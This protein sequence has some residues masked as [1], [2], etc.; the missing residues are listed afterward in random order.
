MPLASF[1]LRSLGIL[2]EGIVRARKFSP[3]ASA[4]DSLPDNLT[5]KRRSSVRR[6][7]SHSSAENFLMGR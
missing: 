3:S 2:P 4:Y 5:T 1:P 6:N 7:S